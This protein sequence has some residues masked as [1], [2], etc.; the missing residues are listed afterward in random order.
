M[1]KDAVFYRH[2]SPA[3]LVILDLFVEIRFL[4]DNYYN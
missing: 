1:K 2:C 4:V 3:S